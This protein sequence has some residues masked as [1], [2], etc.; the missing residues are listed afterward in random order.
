MINR[1]CVCQGVLRE[2]G[3]GHRGWYEPRRKTKRHL[4]LQEG[5]ACLWERVCR[6]QT[7]K[8]GML[9]FPASIMSSST[10]KI[11]ASAE[12]L[13]GSQLCVSEDTERTAIS[14][15]NKL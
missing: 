11:R 2:P 14:P 6:A 8:L 5:P 13:L 10:P 15:T 3:A 1:A 12:V 7:A 4:F 9:N